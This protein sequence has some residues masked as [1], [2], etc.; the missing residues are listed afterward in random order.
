MCKLFCPT[1]MQQCRVEGPLPFHT[2]L[3]KTRHALE[4]RS[5][6]DGGLPKVIEACGGHPSLTFLN[7]HRN[8]KNQQHTR[9]NCLASP[10]ALA[11]ASATKQP[12][13]S[14]QSTTPPNKEIPCTPLGTSQAA[15]THSSA[16]SPG[17]SAKR[18]MQP[19]NH[20]DGQS[21]TSSMPTTLA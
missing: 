19:S 1:P 20:S 17:A 18:R 4:P 5:R 21:P 7:Y 8:K 9:K 6:L 2:T 11:I 14:L 12:P 16:A 3:K 13:N 15:N 10:S